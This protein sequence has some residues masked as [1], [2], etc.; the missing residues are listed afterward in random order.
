MVVLRRTNEGA[1]GAHCSEDD[2]SKAFRDGHLQERSEIISRHRKQFGHRA[3]VAAQRTHVCL[4]SRKFDAAHRH[5]CEAAQAAMSGPIGRSRRGQAD[6]QPTGAS[7]TS[8]AVTVHIALLC[9]TVGAQT[10]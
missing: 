2:K 5:L 3:P 4:P 10:E 1:S 6:R 9:A 8:D 7:V